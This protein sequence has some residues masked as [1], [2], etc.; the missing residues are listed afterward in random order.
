MIFR[1]A[2]LAYKLEEHLQRQ[3]RLRQ[4]SKLKNVKDKLP[5][6]SSIAPN[7][8]NDRNNNN[9]SIRKEEEDKR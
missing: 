6:P 3:A 2:E 8:H 4:L 7:D 1:K 9:N 5:L